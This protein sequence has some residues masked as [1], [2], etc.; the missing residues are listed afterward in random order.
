VRELLEGPLELVADRPR[1][2]GGG[3]ADF[4]VDDDLVEA[5]LNE[6]ELLLDRNVADPTCER[7]LRVRVARRDVPVDGEARAIEKLGLLKSLTS[8][9]SS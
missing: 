3:E 7:Y 5:D 2:H 9:V 4:G 8:R 1:A 6:L